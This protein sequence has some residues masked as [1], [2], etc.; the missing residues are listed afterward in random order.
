MIHCLNSRI[1]SAVPLT[2]AIVLLA[3]CGSNESSTKPTDSDTAKSLAPI[4]PPPP[5]SP[6]FADEE[7]GT[8][9]YVS[10]VS[11]EDRKKGKAVGSVVGF[12]YGGKNDNG[13]HILI[14]VD[15]SGRDITKSY[16][17]EPCVIIKYDTGERIAFSPDSIIGSAF[18]DSINGYLKP[19]ST[20]ANF[21]AKAKAVYPQFVGSVPKAFRGAWDELVQDGCEGREARFVLEGT[22]LYNFEVAWDV[23]K[24]KLDSPTE[25]DIHVTTKDENGNQVDDVLPFKLADGGKALTSREPG[26]SFFRRCP[27][28]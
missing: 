5:P 18:Q 19:R 22:K 7:N 2:F 10:A 28:S 21:E 6:N 1:K 27:T 25:I 15:G 3:A 14:S 24:V 23:T 9:F 12:R 16:C 13:Q 26:G 8:Y 17:S 20:K 4:A 11:E